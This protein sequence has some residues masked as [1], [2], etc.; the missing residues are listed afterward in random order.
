M[1]GNPFLDLL[2]FAI[3]A[4]L[5]ALW[6]NGARARELAI[7]HARNACRKQSVQFLDQTVA[8]ASM[9]PGRSATGSTCLT[10]VFGF[11]FTD[12]G[13]HRDS[14]SVTMNG[15]QLLRVHFPYTR[16]EDG[17]RVYEH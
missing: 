1:T 11:E 17:N 16:D 6:W 2:L 12:Q 15:Q 5:L 13:E 14:G 9:R 10:R 3:P 4:A 8:L 7:E